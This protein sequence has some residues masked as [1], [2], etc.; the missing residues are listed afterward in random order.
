M[1]ARPPPWRIEAREHHLGDGR[2]VMVRPLEPAD[3]GAMAEFFAGLTEREIYYFFR[4]DEPEARR[5]ATDAPRAPA[6]RLLA[7]ERSRALGYAFLQW[8]GDRPPNFGICLSDGAQ[9]VGLGRAL[10]GHLLD[11]AAASGVDRARLSV[12][13]DNWRALRLYQRSGFRLVG[14]FV[15]E[16]QGR[17]Q[18]RMETDLSAPGPAIDESLTVIPRGGLGVASSAARVQAA[19]EARR[20]RLPLVL[21]R[22]ARSDGEVVL[23]ADL[24][25]ER[26]AWGHESG[27]A[28]GAAGATEGWITRLD[29]RTTLVAGSGPDA[30]ARAAERY[31]R[32]PGG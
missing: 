4:L 31:A 13:P 24:G 17:V 22:P 27:P 23:V 30:L 15:N 21:D 25:P 29:G 16:H 26:T 5:L 3:A 18:Y 12:H 9:S 14:D 11:S 28:R 7:V 1:T 20:G 6:Y 8:H 10:I 32:S 19:L 2:A